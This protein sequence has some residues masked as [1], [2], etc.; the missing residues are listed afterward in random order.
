MKQVLAIMAVSYTLLL[1]SCAEEQ[2]EKEPETLDEI[3]YGQ[4]ELREDLSF[5]RYG[6]FDFHVL[7]FDPLPAMELKEP[8]FFKNVS[9]TGLETQ[10]TFELNEKDSILI[11]NGFIWDIFGYNKDTLDLRSSGRDDY[12]GRK[13]FKLE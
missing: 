5:H 3:I 12:F 1:F 8:N 10:G 13:Y 6:D 2:L 9:D 4:W 7:P 11:L